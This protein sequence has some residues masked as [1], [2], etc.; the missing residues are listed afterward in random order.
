MIRSAWRYP[1]ESIGMSDLLAKESNTNVELTTGFAAT[2]VANRSA[3]SG[4]RKKRM[5]NR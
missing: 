1:R 5:L 2:R 4:A 3:Q